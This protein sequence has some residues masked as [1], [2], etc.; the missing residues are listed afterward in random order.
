MPMDDNAALMVGML[1]MCCSFA[2]GVCSAS[3]GAWA[4]GL[5]CEVL[6]SV[7]AF[8]PADPAAA[9]PDCTPIVITACQTAKDKKKC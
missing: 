2:V 8:F 5:L 6:P 4:G 3:A 1:G 7:K 9:G